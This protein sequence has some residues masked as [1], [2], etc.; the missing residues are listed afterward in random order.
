MK[1]VEVNNIISEVR[2]KLDE[3]QLNES[4]MADFLEDN[5]NLDLV[6]RS[7][8]PTAYSFV[9]E[10]ADASMLEGTNGNVTLTIRPNMIGEII[11]PDDFLRLINVRLTS[12][13]S[14]FSKII[15]ED[16]SEYRM[17]SNKWLCG[18]PE[19]PVVAVVHTAQ[20]R[21]LELYKASSDSDRLEAFTYIPIYD[22]KTESVDISERVYEA[23]IYYVAGLTLTTFR[24]ESANSMFEIAKG[25]LNIE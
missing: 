18:N 8:I 22:M 24:E 21:K 5:T 25:L 10:N 1:N 15:T 20:G 13:N 11:L 23:F 4:G 12:W 17:Q 7:C 6:I 9:C 14:S 19:C 2:V 3:I 16:S